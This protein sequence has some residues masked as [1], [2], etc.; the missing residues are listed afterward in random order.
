MTQVPPDTQ[1]LVKEYASIWNERKYGKI[2]DVVS[3][4]FVMHD[5]AAPEGVAKGR[6]GL[7]QFI[8]AVVSGFPD[9]HVTILDMLSSENRVMY[10][11]EM[12]MTHEGEFKEIPPTGEEVEL[13][14]MGKI[15]I[16]DDKVQEHRVY[17]DQQELFEQLGLT[18]D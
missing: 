14:Y 3:E 17:F 10:E 2:P 8:R 11:A 18:D 16:A 4:S 6:D 13:R 1:Q 7:E 12:S 15:N 5:P 9:F